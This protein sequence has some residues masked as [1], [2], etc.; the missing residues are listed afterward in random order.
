[1]VDCLGVGFSDRVQ[2]MPDDARTVDVPIPVEASVAPALG[3]GLTRAL[4]GRLV[5]RMLRPASVGRLIDVMDAIAAEAER[6]GLT[7]EILEAE[8]AGYNAERRDAD[9]SPHS[10]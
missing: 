4:A 7:D 5:S 10:A 9:A 6:R 1:M 3:D 8:L 2:A